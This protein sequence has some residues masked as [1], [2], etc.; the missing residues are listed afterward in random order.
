MDL[1]WGAGS[2]VLEGELKG[3]FEGDM[4]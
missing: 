1:F 4:K 3:G 2:T